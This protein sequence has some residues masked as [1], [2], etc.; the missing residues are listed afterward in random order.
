M[1]NDPAIQALIE[2]RAIVLAALAVSFAPAAGESSAKKPA[3][4]Q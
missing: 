2:A 1:K 3:L 4:E